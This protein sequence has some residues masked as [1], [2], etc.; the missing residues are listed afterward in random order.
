MRQEGL[1]A[2]GEFQHHFNVYSDIYNRITRRPPREFRVEDPQT[3][4]AFWDPE[5][6]LGLYE[7]YESHVQRAIRWFEANGSRA[8]N[9]DRTFR[10]VARYDTAV[11]ARRGQLSLLREQKSNL[12][13]LYVEGDYRGY[14]PESS[15]TT[16]YDI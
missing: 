13:R 12:L 8:F 6:H 2:R 1:E 14:P 3:L 11:N 7:N 15:N 10:A 4:S 5:D 16:H 9:V